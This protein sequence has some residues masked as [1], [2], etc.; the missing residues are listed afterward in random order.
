MSAEPKKNRKEKNGSS[1]KHF[2]QI[3][4]C[5]VNM[6]IS[7]FP[8]MS[9]FSIASSTLKCLQ[10]NVSICTNKC[11]K[12]NVQKWDLGRKQ[13]KTDYRCISSPWNGS[14]IRRSSIRITLHVGGSSVCSTTTQ[15]DLFSVLA[16]TETIFHYFKSTRRKIY[17]EREWYFM[18]LVGLSVL[19]GMVFHLTT[20]YHFYGYATTIFVVN[21]KVIC[22][23]EQVTE[24]FLLL[25]RYFRRE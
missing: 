1:I 25:N 5:P 6:L 4:V 24:I 16:F 13:I 2:N 7:I 14:S 8:R 23:Y 19:N 18:I 21:S 10:C 11:Q 3:N 17:S 12:S 15:H 22:K 9:Y 20:I